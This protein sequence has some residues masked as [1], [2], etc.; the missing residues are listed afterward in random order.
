MDA[1]GGRGNEEKPAGTPAG[2]G[3]LGGG[4]SCHG[5]VSRES[6]STFTGSVIALTA[7]TAVAQMRTDIPSARLGQPPGS[8]S[9]PLRNGDDPEAHVVYPTRGR[10]AVAE[11]RAARLMC[12]VIA[13]ATDYPV[14]AVRRPHRILRRAFCIVS[15]V[16]PVVAPLP[17]V[18]VH[19]ADTQLV[20][21]VRA[22]LARAVELG[23]VAVGQ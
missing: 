16:V 21:L 14:G 10:G 23:Q 5:C 4:C 15:A 8:P 22:D 11:G 12:A 18:A 7:D 17:D 3:G 2:G 13:P 1:R 6:E 9:V 20:R 19:V